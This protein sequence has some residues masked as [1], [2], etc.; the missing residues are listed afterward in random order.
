[1]RSC[2]APSTPSAGGPL[3]PKVRRRTVCAPRGALPFPYPRG[4]PTVNRAW[5]VFW[6]GDRSRGQPSHDVGRRSGVVVSPS[7]SLTAAGPPRIRTGFPLAPNPRFGDQLRVCALQTS[8]RARRVKHRRRAI[9]G[10]PAHSKRGRSW[11]FACASSSLTWRPNAS[12]LLRQTRPL[13]HTTRE[14]QATTPGGRRDGLSHRRANYSR[15]RRSQRETRFPS[16]A[17]GC[18]S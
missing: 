10:Q 3:C 15:P 8:A 12:E 4:T 16:S 14:W 6:L 2:W 5:Q 7:S 9:G 11:I 13:P 1:M 17:L 18:E